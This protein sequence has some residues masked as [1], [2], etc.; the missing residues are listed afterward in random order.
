MPKFK[1]KPV[2]IEA[3]QWTGVDCELPEWAKGK[4]RCH[5]TEKIHNSEYLIVPTLE[6]DMKASINDYIIQGIQG[7]IYPCKPDIF[8]ATYDVV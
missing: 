8:K 1:K 7:E 4:M 3:F 2:V 6:G 5:R